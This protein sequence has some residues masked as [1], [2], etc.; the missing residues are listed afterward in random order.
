M[1]LPLT[2]MHLLRRRGA[3]V[4]ALLAAEKQ[5]LE[6]VHPGVREQQR[7]VVAGH[8]RRARHDAVAVLLEVLQEGRADLVRG[9]RYSILVGPRT[10]LRC[11]AAPACTPVATRS[12]GR[13]DSGYSRCELALVGDRARGRAAACAATTRA[14]PRRRSSPKTSSIAAWRSSLRDARRVRSAMRTR[15]L[16]ALADA[17]L[18]PRD[19]LGH[20]LIVDRALLAQPRDRRVDLVLARIPCGRGAA[21]TCASDSSRRPSILRPSM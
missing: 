2:R 8:E 13:S 17:G 18:G 6:L 9:H 20:P 3:R 4:V 15:S 16:A 10:R 14:A 7:R 11:R 12:P 19:R 1:C 5:V 21:R